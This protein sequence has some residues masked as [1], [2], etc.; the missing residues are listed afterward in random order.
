MS[1][2]LSSKAKFSVMIM[3]E[4][5]GRMEIVLDYISKGVGWI[6][7]QTKACSCFSLPKVVYCVAFLCGLSLKG[8]V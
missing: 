2:G 6:R 1:H 7:D 3:R 5:D 4:R 8:G